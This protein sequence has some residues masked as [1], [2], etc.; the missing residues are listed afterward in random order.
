[1]E[2]HQQGMGPEVLLL[3]SAIQ[4]DD[5]QG[6]SISRVRDGRAFRNLPGLATA[7][8]ENVLISAE[9]IGAFLAING[10][11]LQEVDM[12]LRSCS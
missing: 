6:H 12:N 4:F 1:M 5:S 10:C 8:F 11:A 2:R 3:S 9:A 7:S